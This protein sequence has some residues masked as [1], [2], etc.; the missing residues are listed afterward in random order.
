MKSIVILTLLFGLP[1]LGWALDSSVQKTSQKLEVA[2]IESLAK[3][4]F[5]N[6][7]LNKKSQFM[8]ILNVPS[9]TPPDCNPHH[10]PP[11]VNEC[12]DVACDQLGSYGCDQQS[13]I[14]QVVS[15]C[16]G[17]DGDCVAATCRRL[18]S[19]GC[20]QMSELQQ[21]SRVCNNIYDGRCIDVVCDKLGSYGCDQMT[22]MNQVS[23]I[24]SGRV[25]S[26]CIQS[27]CQRLGSY[28]CDQLSEVQQVAR[29][30]GGS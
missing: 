24:C 12:I 14:D 15:L 29:S 8:R 9:H 5:L 26:D 20:D 27:V 7:Y 11:N 2:K 17:V 21:V 22:E 10:R 3:D 19:Y 6:K 25:D 4:Y 1:N 16:R 13:E 23:A 28:G 30:C 18:G